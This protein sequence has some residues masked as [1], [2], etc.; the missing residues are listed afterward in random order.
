MIGRGWLVAG[1]IFIVGV[2]DSSKAGLSA[3]V[4]YDRVVHGLLHRRT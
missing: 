2:T 4:L 3:A 1:A